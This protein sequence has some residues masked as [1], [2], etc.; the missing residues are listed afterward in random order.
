MPHKNIAT[1]LKDAFS[2]SKDFHG[3]KVHDS[4]P[5]VIIF[6]SIL[7]SWVSV[8]ETNGDVNGVILFLNV[9]KPFQIFLMR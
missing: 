7:L 6:F 4:E 5:C 9:L 1:F 2:P 8:Q 3:K